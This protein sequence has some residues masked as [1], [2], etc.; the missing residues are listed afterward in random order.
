MF[1]QLVLY[2]GDATYKGKE[3]FHGAIMNSGTALPTDP[4]DGPKGTAIYEAVV[5][6]AGCKDKPEGSLQAT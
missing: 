2:D 3:L 6:K 1:D 4:L 5:E